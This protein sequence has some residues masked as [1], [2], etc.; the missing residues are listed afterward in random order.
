M[1]TNILNKIIFAFIAIIG[2]IACSDR[3]LVTA[4]NTGAPMVM[5]LSTDH[6]FLDQNFPNNA[7]LTITWTAAEYSIPVA[8]NYSV[9]MSADEAFSTPAEIGIVTE[10]MRNITFTTKQ[11]NEAAKKIGLVP[12]VVQNMYFRVT[13]Y[14]GAD[15]LP[16]V[17]NVTR[18]SIT[19]YL[20]SPTYEYEDL[21]IIGN[22][23]PGGWD[24][25]ADND[26]LLPL[27]KTSVASQY[28]YTGFFK[29]KSGVDAAGFKMIKV[30]GSWDAQFGKGA[31]EGQLSTD[32]GSGNLSVP[33]DGYYKL[34]V[35][36]EALTYT[37]EPVSVSPTTY[38]SISVIGTVNGNFDNDTQMTQSTFDPHVWV[39]MGE[40][41]SGG[42][43]KFRANNSWDTNWGGNSEYFGTATQGGDNIPLAAEW[44]YDIYFNDATGAYT[45]IPVK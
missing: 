5:D 33:A 18:L 38:T 6:L 15:D 2:L 10:S 41:L 20:A 32:G 11:M 4:N 19:P 3:E 35:D 21:F 7:A 44:D 37:L 43:F 22:A 40:T 27:L 13:A 23:T 8:V 26:F 45:I 14:V 30:K 34:T 24:N 29:A 42:E 17:S 31:A 39:L 25:L 12:N 16:A 9:E 28:T 36:T 1:K